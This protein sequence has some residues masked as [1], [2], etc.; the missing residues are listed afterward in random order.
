MD[1]A[2]KPGVARGMQ[3]DIAARLITGEPILAVGI[4]SGTSADALDLAVVEVWREGGNP[5]IRLISAAMVSY[6]DDLRQFLFRCFADEA[7]ISE[8]CDGHA[9]WGEFAATSLETVLHEAGIDQDAIGFV[10]SHGQT[11]WHQPECGMV[12]GRAVQRG[13]YQIG[14]AARIATRLNVPVICDFRQQDFSLGGQG[15]P[16]VPVCR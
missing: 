12:N 4:M 1:A 8:L 3:E 16:L 10:A 13:T 6:P 2:L 9:K 15:A 14:E 11:I 7:K 5:R